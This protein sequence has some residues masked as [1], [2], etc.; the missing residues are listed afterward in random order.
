MNPL[1]E[2]LLKDSPADPSASAARI[3]AIAWARVST[4]MQEER[5][6]SLTEQLRQIREYAAERG[7]EIVAEYQE[8]AS[9][10]RSD[11]RRAEFHRMLE[12]ARSDRSISA[13]LVHDYSRFSRDS[14]KARLLIRELRQDGIRVVSLNDIDADP[15]TVAGVYLEA[16]TFAKNEAYSREVA[17]HTIKG[18]RANVQTRDPETGWCY[19]NGGQPLWG[20]RTECLIRGEEKRGRP[21][22]K[23]IWIL[24]DRVVSGR[25]V[26]EWTRECLRMAAEGASLD[27]LRDFCNANALPAP[28][29]EFWGSTT[30]HSLLHPHC[31][32]EYAG[33]GVW[34]VRGRNR[35]YNPPSE[36]VVVENAHPAL[37]SEEVRRILSARQARSGLGFSKAANRSRRSRYLLS[38][39]IFTCARCGS[40]MIGYAKSNGK[41]YYVCGSQ[42][43]R[44][45]LG[46]W[47]G[48]YVPCE[49]LESEVIRGL[50]SLISWLGDNRSFVGIVN[51]KL[52]NLW[53]EQTGC[54]SD[55][56]VRLDDIER[57]IDNLWRAIEEG[58]LDSQRANERIK[59]L[60]KEKTALEKLQKSAAGPPRIDQKTVRS[61]LSD[62]RKLLACGDYGMTKE[63]LYRTVKH[64]QLAPEQLEVKITYRVPEPVLNCIASRDTN[65]SGGRI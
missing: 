59:E 43:N 34:N 37:I 3:R 61:Y 33:Y 26:H 36:W 22:I 5:G 14:L 16:I 53:R 49:E 48:V 4:D 52:E 62:T 19:K 31:L 29:K 65:G 57:K 64:V 63:L 24:D 44:K 35:R 28:R 21:I 1:I 38:G 46:C 18:C 40:R 8:A 15:D 56:S 45:G 11:S 54:P 6:L 51:E 9:A 17:F 42:P 12:H 50:D 55:A 13:I 20:Y 25:P 27:E 7:I 60:Q 41:A 10:F 2:Q 32:L 47:P 30:W 39:G 23:S 58:I